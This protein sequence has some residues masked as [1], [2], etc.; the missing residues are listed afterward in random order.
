MV[1]DIHCPSP[2]LEDHA[3]NEDPGF[4][5]DLDILLGEP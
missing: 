5:E 1:E 4:R 3:R 2:Q